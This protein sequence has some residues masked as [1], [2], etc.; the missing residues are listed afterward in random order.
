MIFFTLHFYAYFQLMLTMERKVP[1][2]MIVPKS[3][4]GTSCC[5]GIVL[6]EASAANRLLV[7]SMIQIRSIERILNK[8]FM[9]ATS[10]AFYL[11]FYHICKL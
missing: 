10:V 7:K 3:N 4:Q 2:A 6:P 8:R 11:W 1:E 5:T 9:I